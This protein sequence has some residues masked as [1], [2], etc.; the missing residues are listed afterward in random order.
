MEHSFA[1]ILKNKLRGGQL[2][3][4][5]KML[6][7]Y[8]KIKAAHAAGAPICVPI[9]A[10]LSVTQRCNSKCL[11]CR[12]G[13]TALSAPP[14]NELSFEEFKRVIDDLKDL[15]TEV[16]GITGGEPLLRGDLFDIIGY[17]KRKKMGAHLSTNGN[18]LD[19]RNITRLLESKVDWVNI[20][21]DG[22]SAKSHESVRGTVS[23]DGLR[24]SIA[25]FL[26]LRSALGSRTKLNLVMV[27]N[28]VN[29]A[30]V[31]DMVAFAKSQGVDGIGFMP[32]H[33]L[34]LTGAAVDK[35]RVAD[36]PG[37]ETI[38]RK[39]IALKSTEPLIDNT[40]D[41]LELFMGSFR[42]EPSPVKCYAMLSAIAI[43]TYG[44]VYPCF[45]R[46][47]VGEKFGNVRGNS[48]KKLAG[49]AEFSEACRDVKNCRNCYWNCHTELNLLFNDLFKALL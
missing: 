33:A 2:F 46:L 4:P 45:P 32:F 9:F 24:K 15:G 34:S 5:G 31:T 43:D 48:L 19:E 21:V 41:Y 10:S 28:S 49:S 47:Q 39:L 25:Q 36:I 40:S 7:K 3:W 13:D 20:S 6:F 42:G 30:E 12:F 14:E 1:N 16:V 27:I 38:M 37:A 23:F 11:I 26:Q 17:I 22:V 29:L 35:L 44:N 8:L 18:L